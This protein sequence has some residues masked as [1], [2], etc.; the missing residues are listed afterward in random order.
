MIKP[1]SFFDTYQKRITTIKPEETV[2]PGTIKIYRC[3]PTVYLYQHA[4][5]MVGAFLTDVLVD[6]AR[7][8]GWTVEHVENIT[9]VGHLVGDGDEGQD[10][11][12]LGAKREGKTVQDVVQFYTDNYK[13]QLALL[14]IITPQGTHNPKATDYIEQQYTLAIKLLV[15]KKAALL[16]DGIY[17]DSVANKK[18]V[19]NVEK[20]AG[21]PDST[22][23]DTEFTGREIK[24][25]DK[26]PGDFA[27]WKFVSADTLQKWKVS[28]FPKLQAFATEHLDATQLSQLDAWGTP[29]WHSECVAMISEILGSKQFS[30]NSQ[31]PSERKYEID[32]HIGGEDHIPMHHKNEILQ[33]EALGFRL[34]KYW[35]HNKFL[36][37][38]DKKMS[39]SVGNIFLINGDPEVTGFESIAHKGFTP[40]AFRLMLFEHHYTEQINFTWKKL[41]QSENRLINLKKS[42]AVIRAKYGETAPSKVPNDILEKLRN[43]LR[44]PQALSLFQHLQNTCLTKET[45]YP[46]LVAADK[47]IFKLDLWPI[48]PAE[49]TAFAEQRKQAKADKN[50]S[51]AD[52]LREKVL[53]AGWMIDDHNFGYALWQK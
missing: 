4:G 22:G 21:M 32:I 28:D 42:A 39:K 13:E 23:G 6:T 44:T 5:N 17:F 47:E 36:L 41:R 34:S 43:N 31:E 51:L 46:Q 53:A 10:K 35:V 40:L 33:S 45:L 11:L 29:G 2:V 15:E 49:I 52:E 12:Q 20:M 27:L 3:G 26:H 38:D 16:P 9:D 50:Y 25:T 24:N 7:L 1:I 30:N 14:N 37:M 18:I 19:D 48:I 8:V